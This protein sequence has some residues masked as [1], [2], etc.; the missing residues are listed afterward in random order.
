VLASQAEMLRRRGNSSPGADNSAL[1]KAFQNHL[2][3][4]N[5]SLN[6]RPEVKILRVPYHQV[7]SGPREISE[8]IAEFLGIALD[9]NVM[10]RQVDPAL[11]R[12]RVPVMK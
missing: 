8:K 1:V 11:Y 5:T 3:E 10:S 4:V 12:Q 9:V 6:G 7:L 2:Y